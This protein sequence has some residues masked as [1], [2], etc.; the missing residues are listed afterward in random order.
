M[1]NYYLML[2]NFKTILLN[3]LARFSKPCHELQNWG[4]LQH[5][6]I[7]PTNR[8]IGESGVN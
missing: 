1:L 5:K 2:M 8:F 3:I 7:C 6:K 4:M